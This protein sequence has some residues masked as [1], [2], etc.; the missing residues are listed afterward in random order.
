MRFTKETVRKLAEYAA[1]VSGGRV[2][3]GEYAEG[4]RYVDGHDTGR[5]F[6]GKTATREAALFYGFAAH[7]FAVAAGTYPPAWVDET[8]LALLDSPTRVTR[9]GDDGLDHAAA[10]LARPH[11]TLVAA[12]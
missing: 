4:P 1:E 5:V 11:L 3:V 10:L 12:A 9:A 2:A 7:E 8:L 6:D